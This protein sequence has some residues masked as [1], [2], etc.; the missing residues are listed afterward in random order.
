MVTRM[1]NGV[2]RTEPRIEPVESRDDYNG[3]STEPTET[4]G[5]DDYN[6]ESHAPP[7]A[8]VTEYTQDPAPKDWVF[9]H[10]QGTL[11]NE[12]AVMIPW[13]EKMLG[14]AR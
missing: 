5:T 1:G 6:G 7:P 13:F 12:R 8:V 3:G 9:A 10:V 2:T 14:K 4:N 11:D